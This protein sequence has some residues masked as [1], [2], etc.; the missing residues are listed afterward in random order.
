[1]EIACERERVVGS[2]YAIVSNDRPVD[3][4]MDVF[5]LVMRS[6]LDDEVGDQLLDTTQNG[7]CRIPIAGRG[8]DVVAAAGRYRNFESGSSGMLD[9]VAQDTDVWVVVDV[10]VVVDVDL[11]RDMDASQEAHRVIVLLV[12]FVESV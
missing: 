9:F 6:R 7:L 8:T 11:G 3:S 1:M 12:R 4:E 10:V 2:R 5:V